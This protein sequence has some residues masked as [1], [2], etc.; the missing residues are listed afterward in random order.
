MEYASLVGKISEVRVRHH[1]TRSSSGQVRVCMIG[2]ISEYFGCR[3][4]I[5]RGIFL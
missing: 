3:D 1:D 4:M 5:K 2:E